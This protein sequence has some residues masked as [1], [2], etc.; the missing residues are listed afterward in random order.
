MST[1][2]SDDEI[3]KMAVRRVRRKKG[4][5]SHL[6]VY[7]IVNAFLW[8]IW[9]LSAGLFNW[10]PW[11]GMHDGRLYMWPLWV[12]VFWGIGLLFHCLSVFAFHGGWEQSEV[13]KEIQRIKKSGG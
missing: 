11:W 8:C 7:I 4:F 5:F 10:G 9:A 1:Q 3:R 2:M 12:T 13:E 6:M